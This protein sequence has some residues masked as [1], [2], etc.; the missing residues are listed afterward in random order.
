[1]SDPRTTPHRPPSKMPSRKNRL[2]NVP[3]GVTPPPTLL[4][5]DDRGRGAPE[6]LEPVI[7][8]FHRPEH[9]DNHIATVQ[10]NPPGFGAA[11]ASTRRHVDLTQFVFDS[12]SNRLYLARIRTGTD[13]KVVGD[14]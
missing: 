11:F 14:D 7:L 1:M 8:A 9:M 4:Q 3:I 12:R 13:D 6:S 2:R 10:Q 5:I